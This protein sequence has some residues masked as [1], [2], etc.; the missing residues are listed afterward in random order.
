MMRLFVSL[1]CLLFVSNTIIIGQE[2]SEVISPKT[3]HRFAQS[4]FGIYTG[5]AP[6][7]E[8]KVSGVAGS[9][10]D[11]LSFAPRSATHLNISGMHFW[12]K[13][14]FFINIPILNLQSGTR[15]TDYATG[16]ETGFRYFLWKTPYTAKISPFVGMSFNSL[17]FRYLGKTDDKSDDGSN[18]NKVSYPIHAGVSTIA[19]KKHYFEL[20]ATWMYNN[21]ATY[22][23]DRVAASTLRLPPLQFRIGYRYLLDTTVSAE[24][25]LLNGRT[26]EQEDRL[27]KAGKLNT[28][29]AAVGVSS[30]F[31]L[32]ESTDVA[33][34]MGRHRGGNV[35]IEW[36]AGYYHHKLDAHLNLSYRSI[37]S[38]IS[39]YGSTLEFRRKALSLDLCKSLFDYKGFVPF[40]GISPGWERLEAIGG[41]ALNP[42][43]AFQAKEDQWKLGYIF[44]WDIRPNRLQSFLLRTNV[45]YFPGLTLQNE[46]TGGK[47]YHFDQLEINFIQAVFYLN[48]LF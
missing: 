3:Q 15:T 34:Y 42:G 6:A 11:K 43:T 29:S 20:S 45:R 48:K 40:I 9:E 28:F 16:T 13:V 22:Y 4:G 10:P 44:G 21:K 26:K 30:T 17:N 19:N 47:R 36:G 32:K 41:D 24:E 35:F 2:N 12:G 39:A 14:D 1:C 46:Q 31:F 23:F 7:W 5:Y 8:T 37:N 25:D 27:G 33:P 38:E 18:Y